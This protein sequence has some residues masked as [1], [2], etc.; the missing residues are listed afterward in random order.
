MLYTDVTFI[1]TQSPCKADRKSLLTGEAL[2]VQSSSVNH[3]TTQQA[4][5]EAT[6]HTQLCRI[7]KPRSSRDRTLPALTMDEIQALCLGLRGPRLG[8]FDIWIQKQVMSAMS[9]RPGGSRLREV[10]IWRRPGVWNWTTLGQRGPALL[11]LKEICLHV[12]QP[13]VQHGPHG[14]GMCRGRQTG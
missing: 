6:A 2:E 10:G 11:V 12:G 7:W 5:R 13:G 9:V 4:H 8:S 1:F 14:L 3:A